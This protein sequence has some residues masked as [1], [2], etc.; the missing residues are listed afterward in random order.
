[1]PTRHFSA[2]FILSAMLTRLAFSSRPSIL[3]AGSR[4]LFST[5]TTSLPPTRFVPLRYQQIWRRPASWHPRTY[6]TLQPPVQDPSRPDIYYHLLS[7]SASP[8]PRFAISFLDTYEGD[9]EVV[10]WL[11]AAAG[12]GGE[13]GLND[14]VENRAS[15]SR[16]SVLPTESFL[17]TFRRLLHEA[18][19]DALTRGLDDIHKNG[20]LQLQN[21]WMHIHDDRNIPPLGR[22]GDP[23]DIIATVLVEDGEVSHVL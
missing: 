23:D 2:L 16:L 22:I 20:A 6:S 21:G 1:M 3:R 18:I 4:S 14:F 8:T 17:A 12:E 5:L 11:P 15:C 7:S 9:N 10:G 19:R 13:A